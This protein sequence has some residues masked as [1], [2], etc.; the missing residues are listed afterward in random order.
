MTAQSTALAGGRGTRPGMPTVQQAYLAYV[1]LGPERSLEKARAKLAAEQP[2]LSVSIKTLKRWCR[3]ESWLAKAEAED[4]KM[5]AEAGVQIALVAGEAVADAALR[6]GITHGYVLES[7]KNV[8]ER[9]MQA[10]PV[11]DH[12][13]NETGEYRFDARGAVAA[14]KLMGETI[15]TF[16]ATPPPNPNPAGGGG[17]TING[18]VILGGDIR[19]EIRALMREYDPLATPPTLDVT[20]TKP[21]EP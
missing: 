2:P 9:C 1:A 18:N 8:V 6:L 7:L 11:L 5:K 12:E 16:Q 21:T 4:R 15:S 19:A 13:G 14:L 3:S 10:E 20:P 17:T